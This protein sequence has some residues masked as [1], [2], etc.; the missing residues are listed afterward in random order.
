MNESLVTGI[1]VFVILALMVLQGLAGAVERATGRALMNWIG[2]R[3]GL[4]RSGKSGSP[5]SEPDS[6]SVSWWNDEDFPYSAPWWVRYPL[7]GLI[8]WGVR[9]CCNNFDGLGLWTVLILA[10]FATLA[11]AREVALAAIVGGIVWAIWG[12]F[13]AVPTGAAIIIAALII[14]NSNQK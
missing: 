7:V 13:A 3:I 14:A 4:L 11:L 2:Y 6:E 9:Y 12:V 5:A 10:F 1:V 8:G